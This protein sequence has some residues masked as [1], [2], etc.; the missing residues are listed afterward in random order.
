M[1]AVVGSLARNVPNG[2]KE[3]IDLYSQETLAMPVD[4]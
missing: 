3:D 4:G 2:A 1:G